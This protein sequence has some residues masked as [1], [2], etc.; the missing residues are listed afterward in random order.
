M[1]WTLGFVPALDPHAE[2]ASLV[3]DLL[4]NRADG[5]LVE[6][7]LDG[8]G[9]ELDRRSPWAFACLLTV[10]SSSSAGNYV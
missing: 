8:T 4:H 10:V 7:T 1:F 6:A 3:M 2:F 5:Q 9:I